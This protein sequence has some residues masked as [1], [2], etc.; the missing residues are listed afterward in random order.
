MIGRWQPFH[1]REA[2]QLP[3]LELFPLVNDP[4]F[5]LE[6]DTEQI[7]DPIPLSPAI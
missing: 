2:E 5:W 6:D 1:D 4:E 3:P 7:D